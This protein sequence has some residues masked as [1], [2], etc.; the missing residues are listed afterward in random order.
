[1]AEK[2]KNKTLQKIKNDVIYGLALAVSW[3]AT[4][5]PLK[6]GRKLGRAI[7]GLAW[8]LLGYERNCTMIHLGVAF[9]DWSEQKRREVG[10]E[11]FRNLGEYFFEFWHTKELLDSIES[12]NPQI[13]LD[14]FEHTAKIFEE[15]RGAIVVTG[16]FG[17]WE[18]MAATASKY[19]PGNTIVRSLY[20][21]RLDKILQ[22][23]RREFKYKPLARGGEQLMIDIVTVLQKNEALALLIDQDTKVR[24]VFADF[25]GKPAWTPSGASYLCYQADRDAVLLGNYRREDGMRVVYFTPPIPRPKTG[26]M[27]ADVAEYTAR[28]NEAICKQIGDHPTEWVW[29][30]RRWKTRPEGE[31]K[32]DHPAPRPRKPY[33]Y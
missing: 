31:A 25:F 27:K 16:H 9:P 24:G 5:L 23:H 29:M 8:P 13:V 26:D 2:Q 4:K 11:S 15:G 18:L 12:D 32:E 17:H 30:H 22:D 3:F 21:P 1:M 19:F 14:G 33:R 20:D 10:K 28:L 6:Y 7:G